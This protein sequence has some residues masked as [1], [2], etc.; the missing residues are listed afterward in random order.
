MRAQRGDAPAQSQVRAVDPT[1]EH[2]APMT[3][4]LCTDDAWNVNGKIFH[5]AGGA[6]SIAHEESPVHTI[7]KAGEW[8]LDE[9]I[10]IVPGQLMHG[11]MNPAPPPPDLD[12]PGRPAAAPA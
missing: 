1:P 10:A 8:T 3:V 2:I 6:V 11:I 12:I 5:V 7:E 4:W 9:L